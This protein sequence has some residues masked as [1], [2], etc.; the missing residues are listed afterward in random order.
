MKKKNLIWFIILSVILAGTLCLS[1]YNSVDLNSSNSS[2]SSDTN[3][4]IDVN[5]DTKTITI[6]EDFTQFVSENNLYAAVLSVIPIEEE[7]A[8]SEGYSAGKLFVDAE[9]ILTDTIECSNVV[10]SGETSEIKLIA[11]PET[12]SYSLTLPTSLGNINS[13]LTYIGDNKLS[14]N[15]I[16]IPQDS[17]SQGGNAFGNTLQMGTT[18]DQDVEFIVN[19]SVVMTLSETTITTTVPVNVS[20]ITSPAATDL[21]LT[22]TD[23]LNNM[24]FKIGTTDM[25]SLTKN[26][27]AGFIQTNNSQLIQRVTPRTS[28][29]LNLNDG[30]YYYLTSNG[31]QNLVLGIVADTDRFTIGITYTL[32]NMGASTNIIINPGAGNTINGGTSFVPTGYA[33]YGMIEL[34]LLSATVWH[35]IYFP[36]SA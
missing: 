17:L 1:I 36:P 4:S 16:T 32:F 25:I 13:V 8:I 19:N 7:L 3:T 22:T 27:I 35:A 33:Q 18:D 28:S 5:E 34:T 6:K 21:I 10:F 9:R 23:D 26:G 11:S 20:G 31:S 30:R 29:N 12:E 24:L 2:D 14:W 15:E